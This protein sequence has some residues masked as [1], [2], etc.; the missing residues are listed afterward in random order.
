MSNSW[1][2]LHCFFIFTIFLFSIPKQGG[3]LESQGGLPINFDTGL[4]Y[5]F[6]SDFLLVTIWYSHNLYYHYSYQL[7]WLPIPSIA[8]LSVLEQTL[9]ATHVF[10]ACND[11]WTAGPPTGTY[12]HVI[13][14]AFLLLSY[15]NYNTYI[16]TFNFSKD[17]VVHCPLVD[18]E[19]THSDRYQFFLLLFKKMKNKWYKL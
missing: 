8:L 13:F 11:P 3:R 16:S 5:Q 19:N 4:I 6:L 15:I 7:C 18:Y 17:L 12:H 2:F 1:N 9:C 10:N 14:S